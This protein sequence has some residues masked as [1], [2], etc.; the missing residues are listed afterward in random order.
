MQITEELLIKLG[1]LQQGQ[2]NITERLEE[3]HRENLDAIGDIRRTVHLNSDY[4]ETLTSRITSV[5]DAQRGMLPALLE[6]QR[7]LHKAI[8]FRW[9]IIASLGFLMAIVR[10]S[11]DIYNG[12][13]WMLPDRFKW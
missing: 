5:E 13:R 2:Q 10:Y 4:M 3:R 7:V 11:E 1:E 6:F 8:R 9:F 12:I